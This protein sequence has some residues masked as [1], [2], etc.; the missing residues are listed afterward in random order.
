MRDDLRG[1]VARG[2]DVGGRGEEP[3][4]LL[5]RDVLRLRLDFGRLALA[6]EDDGGRGVAAVIEAVSRAV[7]FGD[8]FELR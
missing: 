6:E 3:L 5:A 1:G 4:E 2:G 7:A 8:V